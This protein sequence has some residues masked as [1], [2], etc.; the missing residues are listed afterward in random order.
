MHT[1]PGHEDR[2]AKKWQK[3]QR[4]PA[5]AVDYRSPSCVRVLLH[6]LKNARCAAGAG[7]GGDGGKWGAGGRDSGCAPAPRSPRGLGAPPGQPHPPPAAAA[8]PRAARL[9]R[10]AKRG[11]RRRLR[12]APVRAGPAGQDGELVTGWGDRE[13]GGG[14][15]G[16]EQPSRSEAGA[17]R[18]AE[19]APET[20]QQRGR[21]GETEKGDR[22]STRLNSSH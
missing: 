17:G 19:P 6:V 9:R 21:R 18:G 11:S 5:E 2:E 20:G 3:G 1:H 14:R 22:K 10:D 7:A 4:G 16:S 8:A 15:G 12:R 13:A